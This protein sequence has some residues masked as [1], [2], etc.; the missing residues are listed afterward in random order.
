MDF[1]AENM[2]HIYSCNMDREGVSIIIV[3]S[4]SR[5]SQ[6]DS[7]FFV[8][9]A[10]LLRHFTVKSSYKLDVPCTLFIPSCNLRL[11]STLGQGW[12]SWPAQYPIA[13]GN[14]TFFL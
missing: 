2:L 1:F 13:N 7:I 6:D 4:F 10:N 3:T 8:I 5:E 14:C 11:E 12:D 9:A